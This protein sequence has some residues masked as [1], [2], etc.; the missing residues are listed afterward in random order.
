MFINIYFVRGKT[1]LLKVHNG[2]FLRRKKNKYPSYTSTTWVGA[3]RA[4]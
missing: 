4:L 3:I 1:R 2:K